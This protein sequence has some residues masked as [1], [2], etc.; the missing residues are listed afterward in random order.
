MNR[1]IPF[2]YVLDT[3]FLL[4]EELWHQITDE[5]WYAIKQRNRTKLSSSKY[6]LL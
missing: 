2:G 1:F 3:T 6:P 4:Q 5:G